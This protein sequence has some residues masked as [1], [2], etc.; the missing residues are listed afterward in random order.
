MR[1]HA[2][3]LRLGVVIIAATAMLGGGV[4]QSAPT[5]A[6]EAG[7][8]P[9]G[10]SPEAQNA[11]ALLLEM[12][13]IQA[14]LA[15]IQRS[16]LENQPQLQKQAEQFQS[17]MINE[18]RAQGFDPLRSLNHIAL[19]ENQIQSQNLNEQERAGLIAEIQEEQR[20]LM[21]AEQ[22]A[23][24]NPQVQQAREQFLTNMLAAMQK[25]DPATD[26]LMNQLVEKNDQL[27]EILAAGVEPADPP[28]RG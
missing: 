11:R 10:V 26:E 4:A 3:A 1:M 7:Q 16:A 14:R 5:Q 19:I 22:A 24:A 17:V 9:S 2:L 12:N 21:E 23:L 25:Q 20:L 13:Q 8:P 15:D 6:P 18:M 27:T 28:N